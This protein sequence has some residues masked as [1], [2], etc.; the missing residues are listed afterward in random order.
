[1]TR[2]VRSLIA[3]VPFLL[4]STV[5][6]ADTFVRMVSGP[7]GGS[8][9]PLGAK[10]AEVLGEK[11]PGIATSNGPGGGVGNVKDV[12]KGSAEIGWTYAHT[13]YNGFTGKGKFD[14]AQSNIRH[15]ATLYPAA[16]QTAVPKKSAIM[17]YRD[18]KNKSISPGKTTFSGYAAAEAVFG[19]YG[20]TFDQVKQNGGTIHHIGYSDSVSLMKDGNLDVFIALTSVPQASF[21]DLDFKPGIRFI[22][23]EP[24]IMKEIL[25]ENPGYLSTVIPK[26]AY[27]GMEADVPTLG[28]VTVLVINKD[29]PGD[30]VYKMTKALWENHDEFV[31]VKKIWNKVKLEDALRGAAIPIHPGAQKYYD[32]MGVK[33]K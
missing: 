31:K 16:L 14:T 15:F 6:G 13:A 2:L 12:S 27:K 19:R 9:Y 25:K 26:S 1:M 30:V 20:L 29:V 7:A 17:S 5:A 33:K 24:D 18:M 28:V 8:W 21:I 32:E 10:I 4:V 3:L 11:V 23:I 22:G